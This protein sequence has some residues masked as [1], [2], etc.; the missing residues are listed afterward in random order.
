VSL[1]VAIPVASLTVVALAV[2]VI[3]WSP[4]RGSRKSVPPDSSSGSVPEPSPGAMVFSREGTCGAISDA[5]ERVARPGNVQVAMQSR[6]EA[7][8]ACIVV[9]A[10][11]KCYDLDLEVRPEDFPVLAE[12]GFQS[13][14]PPALRA[15]SIYRSVAKTAMGYSQ[16]R[17]DRVIV[18][19]C[20]KADWAELG[21]RW[22]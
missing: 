15:T 21:L 5:V 18:I 2:G 10:D 12:R 19:L 4:W 8:W 13:A 9:N 1:R 3:I 6:H 17:G 11:M 7:R 22:P 16:D 20:P 14:P